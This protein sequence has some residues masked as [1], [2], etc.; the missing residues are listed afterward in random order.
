MALQL[1]DLTVAVELAREANTQQKWR[2]L[3]DLATSKNDF[4]LA[5][6][7]LQK[8]QD[9]GG[10]LLLATSTGNDAMVR[11]LGAMALKENKNNIAFLSHLLVNDVDSCLDILINSNRLPEAALYARTYMPSKISYVVEKWR[12]QLSQ[13]NEKAGQSIADPKDYPNLFPGMSDLLEAEKMLNLTE[14]KVLLP[15]SSHSKVTNNWE[16]DVL[17]E[18]SKGG[19]DFLSGD[20]QNAGVLKEVDLLSSKVELIS[21]VVEKLANVA[22]NAPTAT[23]A[24][25]YDESYFEDDNYSVSDDADS[26]YNDN[27]EIDLDDYE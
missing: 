15:A 22:I 9:Y 4:K 21:S 11:D 19:T 1:G 7:C 25:D 26:V 12:E 23:G 16:R 18:L 24:N 6:E 10:L 20:N 3:V 8:A 2:Q 5:Q 17:E 14:R 13:I 27:D